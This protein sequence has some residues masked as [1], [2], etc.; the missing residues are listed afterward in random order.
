M[1]EA[2]AAA[3]GKKGTWA[4]AARRG[5]LLL[6][7]GALGTWTYTSSLVGVRTETR[8]TYRALKEELRR[9][10]HRPH[11]AVLS[12]RRFAVDNWLLNTF[13][14]ASRNSRHLHGDAIDVLVLDVDGDGRAD[15]NDIDIVYA[16]LDQKLIGDSGGVG[17]YAGESGFFNRQMVHFDLRGHRARWH[18]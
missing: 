8:Q 1:P 2:P 4:R 11:L 12:G 10:G 13:G 5:A 18:R 7:L 3:G 16:I 14:G 17:T 6:L 9:A 15:R